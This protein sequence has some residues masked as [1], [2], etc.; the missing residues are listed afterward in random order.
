MFFFKLF[1]I[2]SEKS[3]RTGVSLLEASQ[4][5]N[6]LPFFIFFQITHTIYEFKKRRKEW[7]L[8]RTWSKAWS[9]R[10]NVPKRCGLRGHLWWVIRR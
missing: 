10:L 5:W 9:E 8:M 6:L 7:W 3:N 1:H 2:G 4:K